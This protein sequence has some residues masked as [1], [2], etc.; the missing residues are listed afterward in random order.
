MAHEGGG[1]EFAC[2]QL[3]A[4]TQLCHNGGECKMSLIG[5]SREERLFCE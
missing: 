2:T 5:E 4:E 1:R 3:Q